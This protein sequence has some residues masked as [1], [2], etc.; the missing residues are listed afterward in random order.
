MVKKIS[1]MRILLTVFLVMFVF[2]AVALNTGCAVIER[3][4]DNPLVVNIAVS[5]AVLRYI[6]AGGPGEVYD[7][8]D[9]VLSV[10]NQTLAYIDSGAQAQVDSVFE[11]FIRLVDWDSL[12]LAD[13]YLA[14]QTLHLVSGSIQ[15]RVERGEI[16]GDAQVV[17]RSIVT[18]AISAA[19][20]AQ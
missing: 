1:V 18:T 19:R 15:A 12:S 2:S 4:G 20:Y 14:Q 17:L 7:R 3:A 16:D 6:E 10:M 5:Q 8:R 11:V 13:Q 9:Q